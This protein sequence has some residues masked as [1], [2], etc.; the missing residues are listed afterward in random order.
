MN[1]KSLSKELKLAQILIVEP[2]LDILS[3]FKAFLDTLG[4]E[5]TT[6]ADGSDALNVFLEK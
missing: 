3:L 4:V 6:V 2:E 1:N 5:S